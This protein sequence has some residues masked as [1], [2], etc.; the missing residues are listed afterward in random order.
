MQLAIDPKLDCDFTLNM[1]CTCTSVM[2][3]SIAVSEVSL[4]FLV[5]CIFMA[6]NRRVKLPCSIFVVTLASLT[7]FGLRAYN[8]II[9]FQHANHCK[10]MTMY[11]DIVSVLPQAI[12]FLIFAWIIFKL[13]FVWRSLLVDSER[14][15]KA[16]RILLVLVM[17]IYCLLWFCLWLFQRYL[18]LQ[19]ID[20]ET[21][22]NTEPNKA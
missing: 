21:D 20:E 1:P 4:Y 9:V 6:Y 8:V 7:A 18:E 14:R 22:D 15:L 13:L 2:G 3:M 10:R 19:I 11:E 12:F 17:R 16:E 5:C